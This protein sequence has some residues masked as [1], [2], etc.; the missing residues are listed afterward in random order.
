[1]NNKSSETY[2]EKFIAFVDILGF[3]DLVKQSED[4]NG[5]GPTLDYLM[6]LTA[7]LGSQ[8]DCARFARS[9]PVACPQSR[10]I[11]KDLG[12]RI[13]QISDCMVASAEISPAGL[14]NLIHH[15]FGVSIQLLVAGHLCRGFITRGRILH[16][17][18]QFIGSGYQNAVEGEKRVSIFQVDGLDGGTP[19]IQ[20]DSSICE[21]VANETD[22][23]VMETFRRI[24]ESDG[25]DT[26]VSPFPA[27]RKIPSTVIGPGFDP[28]KWKDTI[29][30]TKANIQKWLVQ[31][32]KAEIGAP[33]S[34]K[35][36]IAHYRRKLLEIMAVKDKEIAVMDRFQGGF[37]N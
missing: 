17:Q 7:K 24:T 14:I 19:F 10:Y 13:T 33:E 23:S 11:S 37:Q 31:M 22:T 8:E 32:E 30:D 18:N 9:G 36:K 16:T 28:A 21:Y 2:T 34:G 25:K 35:R 1:V 4:L 6:N 27:L 3:A 20:V 12:F 29:K 26:A 5:N 15:C